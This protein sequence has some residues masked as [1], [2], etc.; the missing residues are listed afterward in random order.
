MRSEASL[1]YADAAI[2][3]TSAAIS[4][5]AA[6]TALSFECWSRT[7]ETLSPVE[8]ARR[9]WYRKPAFAGTGFPDRTFANWAETMSASS[10][11]GTDWRASNPWGPLY[12]NASPA[13]L[14]A[15]WLSLFPLRGSPAAWPLAFIMLANGVPRS[16]AIPAA[17]AN[18]AVMEATEVMTRPLRRV[19]AS[20][21]GDSGHAMSVFSSPASFAFG[22]LAL[23][24]S[25]APWL[26]R[27]V[28]PAP[29]I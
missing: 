14:G 20:Y 24:M 6:M 23:A 9:S 18:V 17:E 25:S 15:A 2:G 8:P 21:R 22:G 3:C 12:M 11:P 7:M 27:A 19:A 4:A 26:W 28:P 5:C 10:W 1:D 13:S 29:F 16:V